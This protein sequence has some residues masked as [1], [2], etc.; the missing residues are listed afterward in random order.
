M[1]KWTTAGF[2]PR[3]SLIVHHTDAVGEWEYDRY[4]RV[5]KLDWALEIAPVNRWIVVDM[6]QDWKFTY[7]FQEK[8]AETQRRLT[9]PSVSAS[10]TPPP[11]SRSASRPRSAGP[12]ERP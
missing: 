3:F 11:T 7:P 6:K 8:E 10:S 1:F 12:S 9:V 5:G 4:S 2:G